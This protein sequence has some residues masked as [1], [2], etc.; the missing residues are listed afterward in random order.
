MRF[1][2]FGK[3]SLKMDIFVGTLVFKRFGALSSFSRKVPKEKTFSLKEKFPVLNHGCG[4]LSTIFTYS[5]FNVLNFNQNK[6]VL[7]FKHLNLNKYILG[8]L[9]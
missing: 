6:P 9:K 2:N 7:T 8:G 5:V 4:I 3:S 1:V